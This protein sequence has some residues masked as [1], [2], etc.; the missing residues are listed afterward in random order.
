MS[1][2]L[3]FLL[4]LLGCRPEGPDS[5][6]PTD[7]NAEFAY[8]DVFAQRP[9][10]TEGLVNTSFMLEEVLEYGMLD[11]ACAAYE[12]NP[13]NRRLKLMCGKW[14]FFY[15]GFS[16]QGIPKKLV[17]WMGR[18]F[19]D[20]L[21]P[22]FNK[23]GLVFDPYLSTPEQPL[24][25]GLGE[26]AELNFS[27]TSALTCASCHFGQMPDG[28][29]AVGYPNLEYEY[30]THILS[31]FLGAMS[32]VP[33]FN[34]AEHHPDAIALVRPVLDRFESDFGLEMSLMWDLLPVLMDWIGNMPSLSYENEGNYATW[35]PGTMDFAMTP[36]PLEDDVHTV[37]RILPL[38]GIPTREE[39][40]DY[41]ME[42]AMLAWTGSAQSLGQFLEGVVVVGG[43]PADEWGPE[44]LS[45]LQEYLE[46]LDAPAPLASGDVESV[47]RG[48]IL[49]GTAGCQDC[50]AGPRGGGL[51]VFE[52][53]EIGTDPTL[54]RWGDGDGDGEICC[55]V[56]GELTGGVKAPRLSGLYALSRFLHNGSLESLEQLL[57]VDERPESE[58]PPYA[59]TGHLYGCE[60]GVDEKKDLLAFLESI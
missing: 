2:A 12:T 32:I 31:M 51:E 27:A 57:C 18:N 1:Y 54:A 34:E 14:M 25:L 49:F 41:G 21:G 37:S 35:L 44:E 56:E 39:E 40:A 42:S 60:L 19:P 59:N 55:G 13:S 53:D 6:G 5:S 46:S 7:S 47:E 24:Y 26:G 20:E 9:D 29:Y 3:I 33:G 8:A 16:T 15:E 43:G 45:P 17:D 10:T 58:K 36:L 50:H 38:W 28:R 30:G 52:F 22:G 48:R 4:T 11:E 23:L